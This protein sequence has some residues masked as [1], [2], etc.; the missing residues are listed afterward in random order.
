MKKILPL[1]FLMTI[2]GAGNAEEWK[3]VAAVSGVDAIS[4]IHVRNLL[5]T[6]GIE[7]RMG[8]SVVYGIEVPS[9]KGAEA[10]KLLRTDAQLR[11]YYIF[12]AKNDVI[13]PREYKER[14][15]RSAVAAVLKQPDYP[16]TSALGRFLRS[17]QIQKLTAK[18]PYIAS[19]KVYERAYLGAPH[20]LRTGYDVELDLQD[21]LE[22]RVRGYSGNYQ[23][24][25]DG[26][27]VNVLGHSEWIQGNK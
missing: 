14:V 16:P 2:A 21:A 4:Q 15:T 11:R 24:Y 25:D 23:I 12:F 10:A 18:Y 22:R 3:S 8:G 27:T 5:L 26:N 6:H 20:L 7:S 1:L 9:A 19:L 13:Q 17:E